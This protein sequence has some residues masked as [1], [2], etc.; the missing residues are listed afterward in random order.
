VKIIT[1]V[2]ICLTTVF[3][4]ATST[5]SKD[6]PPPQTLRI[7]LSGAFISEAGA[8]IYQQI[9]SYVS[10]KTGLKVEIVTGLSYDTINKML[11]AGALA[12]GFVCGLPYVLLNETKENV[13]LTIAPVMKA[14]RYHDKPV[15][16]SELIVPRDSSY[17]TIQD[18]RGKHF[19][20]NDE[21]SNSGYNL[22]RDFFLKNGIKKDFFGKITR[23]GSHEESIRAVANKE[24][25][26]SF[27]DS[28]VLDYEL[29]TKAKSAQ[30]VRVIHS[31]GPAGVP[32][33]VVSKTLNP[34]IVKELTE[35][36]VNMDKD[37][38][39][40]KILD[41]GLLRRFE[42]V[43]DSNYQGIREKYLNAKSKKALVIGE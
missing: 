5:F 7:A 6:N 3:G 9:A 8:G 42:I 1:L 19:I 17:K 32:P 10:D 41:S 27:V 25:D 43:Y 38:R 36:F 15:Y 26:F 28:L 12:G 23:S 2:L 30:A 21:L 37:P 39:G 20:Y 11:K 24:A 35:A 14:S 4:F 22:P 34:A 29:H 13:I 18:L 16:Y 40:Q 33:L 31:L